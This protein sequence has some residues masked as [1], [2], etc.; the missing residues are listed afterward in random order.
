MEKEK[1]NRKKTNKTNT[2]RKYISEIIKK[3]AVKIIL[4]VICV[5][6]LTALKG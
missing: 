3:P 6:L 4:A 2:V 1:N 5:L